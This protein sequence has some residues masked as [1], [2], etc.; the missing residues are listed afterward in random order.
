[1]RHDEGTE[2]WQ[3][4]KGSSDWKLRIFSKEIWKLTEHLAWCM[5]LHV[6]IFSHI[7]NKQVVLVREREMGKSGSQWMIELGSTEV[8]ALISATAS[9]I[10]S[11]S[12]SFF[13]LQQRASSHYTINNGRHRAD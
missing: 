10:H 5:V 8:L 7:P 12:R 2:E 1:M 4:G 13:F 11:F 9:F 3:K 6:A